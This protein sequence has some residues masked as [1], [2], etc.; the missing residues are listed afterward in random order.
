MNKD[1]IKGSW[2]EIAGKARAK[3]GKLTDNDFQTAKGDL[4]N[5]QGSLEKAY[6]YSKEEAKRQIDEFSKSCGCSSSGD[7]AA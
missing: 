3:W 6:G 5:L 4:Q 7:K 2:D 1:T